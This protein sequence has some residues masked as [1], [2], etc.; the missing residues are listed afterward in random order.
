MNTIVTYTLRSNTRGLKVVDSDTAV[1]QIRVHVASVGM[2]ALNHTTPVTNE[3]IRVTKGHQ[4]HEARIVEFT[5]RNGDITAELQDF[6]TRKLL[7]S[8][9]M[10]TRIESDHA[11]PHFGE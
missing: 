4:K 2:N 5:T 9:T 6:Y 1:D 8:V 3:P 11:Q 7:G 10:F